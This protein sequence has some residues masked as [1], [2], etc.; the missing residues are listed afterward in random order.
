MWGGKTEALVSRLVRARIQEIPTLA[1]NAVSN[2][3]FGT[4]DIRAHSGAG[5]PAVPVGKGADILKTVREERPKVVGIDEFFMIEGAFGAVRTMNDLGIKVVV[6]TLDMDS[7]G[8][9]WESVGELLGIAEEVVKC[10]AVCAVCKA[11]AYF[12]FRRAEAPAER[13]QRVLVGAGDYYEPRC[14]RCFRE[15]QEAKRAASGE[16]SLFGSGSA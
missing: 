15:G 2:T 5:F 16:G 4:R 10:P 3:R 1:F 12:T 6:S 13:V 7:E 8:K 11:D 9:V 14:A